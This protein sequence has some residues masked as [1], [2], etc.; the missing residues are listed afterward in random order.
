MVAPM[1]RKGTRSRAGGALL[2]AGI[3]AGALVGV[4]IGQ[5]SIGILAGTCAGLAVLGLIWWLDRR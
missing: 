2:A 3:L 4:A 1:S 5:P